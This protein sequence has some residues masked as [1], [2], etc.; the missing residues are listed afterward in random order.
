MALGLTLKLLL[1]LDITNEKDVETGKLTIMVS[2]CDT[3]SGSTM[4]NRSRYGLFTMIGA[5]VELARLSAV[6]VFGDRLDTYVEHT[7][8]LDPLIHDVIFMG[9]DGCYVGG[10]KKLLILKLKLVLTLLSNRFAAVT[11]ASVVL[12]VHWNVDFTLPDLL[13]HTI[14]DDIGM[15]LVDEISL[16]HLLLVGNC[17]VTDPAGPI[18]LVGTIVSIMSAVELTVLGVNVM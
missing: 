12:P 11:N 9:S 3:V 16:L 2:V 18:A 13:E 1:I 7:S 14:D 6:I 4:E 5:P 8:I 10:D 15:W 17:T